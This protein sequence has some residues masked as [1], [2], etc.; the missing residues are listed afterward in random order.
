MK[1]FQFA[2]ALLVLM[3]ISV[4]AN[5]QMSI[6]FGPEAGYHFSKSNATNDL[7]ARSYY[8]RFDVNYGKISGIDG[9]LTLGVQIKN[10][11]LIT[12]FKFNQKGG[13]V[14][15]ATRDPNDPF[16][17]Q[18]NDGTQFTDVGEY[19]VTTKHNWLSIPILAR[20]QFGSDKIKIGLAIGPQINLAMG[21]YKEI[22]EFNLDNTNLP[23]DESTY[24]FGNTSKE[25]LKKSHLSLVIQPHVALALGE[26]GSL[27]LGL[28]IESGADMVN[29][30]FIVATQNG[31]RN[32]DA[33]QKS[34][35]FGFHVAYEHRID[36][37]VGT[38]Y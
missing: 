10:W 37:Q 2:L 17:G 23:D 4:N 19:T 25:L 36:L 15:I 34:N 12:G 3:Q 24:E 32:I 35:N 29:E 7:D 8:S 21:K 27:R 1:F 20:G 38:R 33:T 5:A 11:A 13:N 9:G 16:V 30:N 14:T 31:V 22:T 6:I 28:T 26:S 18:T